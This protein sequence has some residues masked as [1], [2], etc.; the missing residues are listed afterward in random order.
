MGGWSRVKALTSDAEC[1]YV[2][3]YMTLRLFLTILKPTYSTHCSVAFGLHYTDYCTVLLDIRLL[4]NI[5][6][7]AGVNQSEP[8]LST[9]YHTEDNHP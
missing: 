9:T 7:T 5:N 1:F 6:A 4:L 3:A 8:T 2:L